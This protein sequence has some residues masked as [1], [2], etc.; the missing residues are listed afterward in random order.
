MTDVIENKQVEVE[1]EDELMKIPDAIV[2]D[3]EPAKEIVVQEDDEVKVTFK[4][5]VSKIKFK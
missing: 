2:E 5:L 1:S 3:K 4:D